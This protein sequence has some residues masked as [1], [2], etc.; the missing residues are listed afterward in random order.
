MAEVFSEW[1]PRRAVRRRPYEADGA[2]QGEGDELPP[3]RDD[4]RRAPP[5]VVLVRPLEVHLLAHR[6]MIC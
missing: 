5:L 4:P 1:L 6:K 3:R 2:E